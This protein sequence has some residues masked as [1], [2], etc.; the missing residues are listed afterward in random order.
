M[1]WENQKQVYSTLLTKFFSAFT[2]KSKREVQG[3]KSKC[4]EQSYQT[5]EA[6]QSSKSWRRGDS[7]FIL[8]SYCAFFFHF[9]LSFCWVFLAYSDLHHLALKKLPKLPRKKKK[10][11]VF[12]PSIQL[13]AETAGFHWYGRYAA[14]M[15]DIFSGTK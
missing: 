14:N 12:R 15:A 1:L 8:Q 5:E 11:F 13:P 10:H 6:N 2:L 3:R 4:R 9:S 7:N